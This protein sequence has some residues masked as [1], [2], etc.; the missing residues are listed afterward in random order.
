M[1]QTA[2]APMGDVS[3]KTAFITGGADGIGLGIARALVRAGA[4]V[5]IADIREDALAQAKADLAADAQVEIVQLDVTDRAAFVRAADAAEARF[6][7][8][9]MLIGNAGVGVLGPVLDA[10]FDDWDWGLGVNLGGVINGLVTILP[11]I[12]AHGEGGQIVTTSSQSALIPINGSAIYTA[13]KAAV[14]GLSEAI[15]GSWQ[16]SI[17]ACPPSCRDRCKA[18]SAIAASCALTPSAKIAVIAS[19]RRR[20]S[21]GP[22]RRF[23]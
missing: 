21:S 7:K 16:R 23:G 9:H 17:S 12:R 10:R 1:T 11:R 8:I 6:G 5:V 20:W 18:I 19:M 4:N 14:L 2:Q 3:G 15:R 22:S 13:A